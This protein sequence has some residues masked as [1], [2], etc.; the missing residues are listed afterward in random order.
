MLGDDGTEPVADDELLYRRIPVSTKWYTESGLSP[1][2]FDP[3]RDETTGISFRNYIL[4]KPFDSAYRVACRSSSPSCADHIL[5]GTLSDVCVCVAGW[6]WSSPQSHGVRR[7]HQ[8]VP[9]RVISYQKLVCGGLGPP[10]AYC[11]QPGVGYATIRPLCGR[12]TKPLLGM[13]CVSR[14]GRFPG[15]RAS[16][17]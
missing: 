16:W 8:Y 4:D 15:G 7:T 13:F 10:R 1:E 11:R 5:G 17:R 3:R 9:P 14:N 2:A 12:S 6:P